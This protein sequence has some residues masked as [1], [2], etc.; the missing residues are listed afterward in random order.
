MGVRGGPGSA[1]AKDPVDRESSAV[2][3]IAC[4]FPPTDF[5]N[6]GKPGEDA[7]GVGILKEFKPAFGSRSDTVEGRRQLGHEI[8]PIYWISSNVPPTLIIHGDADKLVPIQQAQSFVEKA[9]SMGVTA[10]LVVKPGGQHGWP[11]I[12]KDMPLLADWFDQYLRG[13]PAA[14]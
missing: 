9:N 14:R 5:L 7:V 13:L 11:D 10:K 3:A 12:S 4:F 8:S 1:D 6:Y 2:Q